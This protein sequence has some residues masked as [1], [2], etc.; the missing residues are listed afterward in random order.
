METVSCF[1]SMLQLPAKAHSKDVDWGKPSYTN[2]SKKNLQYRNP[3]D[4]R[5]PKCEPQGLSLCRGLSKWNG[6]LGHNAAYRWELHSD[7][8]EHESQAP[9]PHP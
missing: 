1:P 4:A 2:P 3:Q 9:K 6:V 5:D 8:C 7:Y